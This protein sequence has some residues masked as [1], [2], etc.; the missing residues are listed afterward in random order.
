[1]L[2]SVEVLELVNHASDYGVIGHTVPFKLSW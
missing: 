1:M 2:K